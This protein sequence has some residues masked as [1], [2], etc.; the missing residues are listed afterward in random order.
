MTGMLDITDAESADYLLRA[1]LP[2]P[3]SRAP[4][5]RIDAPRII[6]TTLA[7]ALIIFLSP[8]ILMVA[9]AIFALDPGPIFFAHRRIGL[10]GREFGCL[11]FRT[12]R[13][14]ADA[15]LAQLLERDPAARLEWQREHKLRN[16]PRI[17]WIG[18]FLRQWSFDELPQLLNVL[19]GEM[20][21]VGPRPIVMAEVK[22]YGRYYRH[23][24]QVRPG[25]TGL[26]QVSGRNDVSYSRR[27]AMDVHYSRS[28]RLS[29]DLWI[30]GRTVPCVIRG[31][32]C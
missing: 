7:A 25:L 3:S 27:V 29:L 30:L 17:T 6:D 20:S 2:M 11:K 15:C 12:M 22:R 16:D 14:D 18:S 28:K 1:T 9:L 31:T 19:R 8:V 26:W 4:R 21:L 5:L 10:G 32:G 24:C 23:Y 13:V